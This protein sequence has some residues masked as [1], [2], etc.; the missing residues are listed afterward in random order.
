[1]AST[2]PMSAMV[3]AGVKAF[4]V[5]SLVAVCA[6]VATDPRAGWAQRADKAERTGRAES[7]GKA[8]R[9]DKGRTGRAEPE[10]KVVDPVVECQES[11]KEAGEDSRRACSKLGKTCENACGKAHAGSNCDELCSATESGC[12]DF[13]LRAEEEEYAACS[14]SGGDSFN[15]PDTTGTLSFAKADRHADAD[16]AL[17]ASHSHLPAVCKSESVEAI[18]LD[19]DGV[20][21]CSQIC[22]P[23]GLLNIAMKH[24]VVRG[25]CVAEGFTVFEYSAAQN[26]IEYNVYSADEIPDHTLGTLGWVHAP[27]G[28]P[29]GALGAAILHTP[30]V[31][32][33]GKLADTMKM[34]GDAEG[35]CSQICLPAGLLKIAMK[36]GVT[37]GTCSAT[38][39]STFKYSTSK[40]GIAYNVYALEPAVLQYHN[41]MAWAE[42]RNTGLTASREEQH[43][44]PVVCKTGTMSDAMALNGDGPGLCSQV[45]LPPGLLNIAIKH[46][47]TIG[48][49][50]TNGFKTFKYATSKSNIAYNVYS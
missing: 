30:A 10:G 49:C 13:A 45:C 46:G 37:R 17:T 29:E 42:D 47:I 23:A 18:K 1:M 12:T 9:A 2:R 7:E 11:V 50:A 36:H 3:K 32:S 26:H 28:T 15:A 4:V 31:C 38:G 43:D 40:A 6:F 19:G 39:F 25:N 8:Q 14:A 5:L 16:D 48:T 22:L 35:L 24:G 20:G 27:R 33:A 21:L 41:T 44:K 34:D